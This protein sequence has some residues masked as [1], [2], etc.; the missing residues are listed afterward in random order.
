[1][2]EIELLRIRQAG[3]CTLVQDLGRKSGQKWGFSQG[4][5]MDEHAYLWANKLL[6]NTAS[7]A[8]LEITLGSFVCEF[9]ASLH[10]A[11]CGAAQE[12]FINEKH[13]ASWQSATINAGDILR[14]PLAKYGLRTYLAVE[15]G[16]K[17]S[18]FLN[19][20]SMLLR[21]KTGPFDG[22]PL[23]KNQSLYGQSLPHATRRN[24]AVPVRF[25][26]DYATDLEVEVLRDDSE[27]KN[28]SALDKLFTCDF[29]VS[30]KSNRMACLL[31][32]VRLPSNTAPLYSFGTA[33]GAIQLPPNGKPI[34]LLRERQTIGGYPQIGCVSR[35]GCNAL[36]QARAGQKIRFRQGDIATATAELR[37]FYRFFL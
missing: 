26:P 4:G 19:S 9:T 10:I 25:I 23:T 8:A 32:G 15:S 34:I 17:L 3:P 22:R 27:G 20:A 37:A 28:T 12:F 16:F 24:S 35:L 21:E 7:C 36:G 11:I 6:G 30:E 33:L 5:V 1:M 31:E 14:V 29:S 13:Y 2:S 18:H